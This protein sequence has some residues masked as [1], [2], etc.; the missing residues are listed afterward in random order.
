M[1]FPALIFSFIAAILIAGILASQNIVNNV[2][3]EQELWGEVISGLFNL[4]TAVVSGDLE[5]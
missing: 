5:N 4:K 1:K 2:F 3:G